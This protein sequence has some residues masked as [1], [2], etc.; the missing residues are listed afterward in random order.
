[1]MKSI[2]TW[3][4]GASIAQA[5]CPPDCITNANKLYPANAANLD[6]VFTR[7]VVG[8][9]AG[10][11]LTA[12]LVIIWGGYRIMTA[13]DDAEKIK[14]GRRAILLAAIGLV[15]VIMARVVIFLITQLLS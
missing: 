13:G 3:L 4:T 12:T 2:I 14:T 9:T 10:A 6:T 11:L 5:A 15:I 8:Q 1:M 7:V